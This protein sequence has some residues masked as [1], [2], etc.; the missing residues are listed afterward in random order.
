MIGETYNEKVFALIHKTWCKT[1]KQTTI[2]EEMFPKETNHE[3]DIRKKF[4]IFFLGMKH[5]L[6]Q[7]QSK[8]LT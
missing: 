1:Q 5:D 4:G 3:C 6:R 8:L 7:T 2:L